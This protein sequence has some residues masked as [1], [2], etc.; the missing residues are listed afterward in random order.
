MPCY[1]L[2]LPAF[3][4]AALGIGELIFILLAIIGLYFPL[5]KKSTKLPYILFIISML[6]NLYA[7]LPESIY[8]EIM[9]KTPLG[10]E[11]R[12]GM[13]WEQEQRNNDPNAIEELDAYRLLTNQHKTGQENYLFIDARSNAETELG[14]AQGFTKIRWPDLVQSGVAKGKT[15]IATCWTG[16]RGSEVCAKLKAQGIDCKYLKSGLKGWREKNLP[17]QLAPQVKIEDLGISE[18]YTNSSTLLTVREAVKAKIAGATIIEIRQKISKDTIPGS[19]HLPFSELPTNELEY[20]INILPHK[21]VI[22]SCYG[23][24]S[25]SEAS[26]LGWE[27]NRLG[28]YYLGAYARGAMAFNDIYQP[29]INPYESFKNTIVSYLK[30]LNPHYLWGY[31]FI[32]SALLALLILSMKKTALTYLNNF[33]TR[34]NYKTRLGKNFDTWIIQR[35]KKFKGVSDSFIPLVFA[36]LYWVTMDIAYQAWSTPQLQQKIGFTTLSV[37]VT[38]LITFNLTKLLFKSFYQNTWSLLLSLLLWMAVLHLIQITTKFTVI[39]LCITFGLLLVVESIERIKNWL[40]FSQI[41]SC[42]NQGYIDLNHA[43]LLVNNTTKAGRLSYLKSK[44]F[45]VPEGFV[46]RANFTLTNKTKKNLLKIQPQAIRSSALNEDTQTSSHAGLNLS[47]VP[48]NS[49]THD[50]ERVYLSYGSTHPDEVILLQRCIQPLFSGV[51]FSRHPQWGGVSLVEW[52]TGLSSARM[53]G[54]QNT[55][56]STL[57]NGKVIS[58]SLPNIETVYNLLNKVEKIYG[59]P[60]DIEWAID[61]KGLWLL[62]ARPQTALSYNSMESDRNALLTENF[63]SLSACELSYSMINCSRLSGSLLCSLW[64]IGSSADHAS[65]MAMWSWKQSFGEPNAYT[66]LFGRIWNSN[67]HVLA[68][69]N[70]LSWRLAQKSFNKIDIENQLTEI[71]EENSIYLALDWSKLNKDSWLTAWNKVLKNWQAAQTLAF[72]CEFMAEMAT[73]NISQNDL[74]LGSNSFISDNILYRAT[75]DYEISIPRYCELTG[76]D[77]QKIKSILFG[78][79]I[80]KS[81][82]PSKSKKI[83][84]ARQLINLRERYKHHTLTC[85]YPLR[86]AILDLQQRFGLGQEIFELSYLEIPELFNGKSFP[87]WERLQ[88]KKMILPDS[89][90]SISLA[91]LGRENYHVTPGITNLRGTVVS[92]PKK[93]RGTLLIIEGIEENLPQIGDIIIYSKFI[94]PQ[95]VN[96]AKNSGVSGLCSQYGSMLSHPSVLA[97][98]AQITFVTQLILPSDWKNGI[99]VEINERGEISRVE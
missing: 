59:Y 2:P 57:V 5:R 50:L 7:F 54:T 81:Q 95:L 76:T 85:F 6:F 28:G 43:Y 30:N 20:Q 98:E 96:L 8:Y 93:I 52:G 22:V 19:I 77:Y 91:G 15:V 25:C 29:K 89:L 33:K 53:E 32:T 72:Y 38:C 61:S 46:V 68:K 94:S 75:N 26:L 36:A 73:D 23:S 44:G 60:V 39:M 55:E 87:L 40:L 63:K 49:L 70:K 97:R 88:D 1:A 56:H 66:Y 69:P 14:T 58:N 10:I 18:Q 62:Q 16:M 24:V 90:D 9:S 21:P 86:L 48:S 12:Q 41:K 64:D 80:D 84:F 83:L 45:N 35:E 65:R 79:N 67:P 27:I 51:A 99:V 4:T 82:L 92:E 11:E 13:I 31:L 37:F 78:D 42:Y 71:L 3:F 17:L 47:V 74:A 34:Q